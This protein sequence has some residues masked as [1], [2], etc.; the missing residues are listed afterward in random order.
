MTALDSESLPHGARRTIALTGASGFVGRRVLPRLLEAGF[1][2][3]SLSRSG[4]AETQGVVD[5]RGSLEEDDGLWRLVE[6]A[7]ALVHLAGVAHTR[8]TSEEDKARARATN[9]E[10]ARRLFTLAKRAGV[11]RLVFLSSAH[12]YAGQRGANL[13]ETSPTRP[14][15]LYAEMKLGAE[16][17]ART[18]AG[19]GFAVVVLRPPLVYGGGAKFNL[20]SLMRA[21]RGGYY[22]HPG[23]AD[24]VRSVVA[25]HTLA[26]AVLHF[27]AA[28]AP[29]GTWNVAD[30]VPGSLRAWVDTLAGMLQARQPR[31]VPVGL[32]RAGAVAGSTAA[33]LGLPAP[34][35]VQSLGK[36]TDDFWLNTDALAAT[37]FQW[38]GH[39][40][41]DLCAMADTFL[42]GGGR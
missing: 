32:L 37:G 40:A 4:A 20:E 5:V 7:E 34:L 29:E 18:L 24:A 1:A 6:G 28:D 12:V 10:G 2:V 22:V 19:P 39:E 27:L 41:V 3:R 21:V 31:V 26:D 38:R 25:V 8:L 14:D 16:A 15:G 23:G 11:R 42:Q 33:A 17:A 30:R 13:T 9:L 36:L 35:T